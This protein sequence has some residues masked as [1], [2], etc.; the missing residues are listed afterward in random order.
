[1]LGGEVSPV[2]LQVKGIRAL[3]IRLDKPART[4]S[5]VSQPVKY[6]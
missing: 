3:T 4:A 6:V 5:F 1:M 2:Y